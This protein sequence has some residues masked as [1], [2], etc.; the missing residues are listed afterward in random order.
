MLRKAN[1]TIAAAGLAILAA[2][3][4]WY[5]HSQS[6]RLEASSHSP[7]G[8]MGTECVL[9]AVTRCSERARGSVALTTAED[10]LRDVESRMSRRLSASELSLLNAAPAGRLVRLSPETLEVLQISKKLTLQTAGAFNVTCLPVIELWKR[11][12]K[13]GRTPTETELI[14]ARHK[15]G[16]RHIELLKNG[17]RKRIDG[18]AVDLG[19]IAKGYAIDKAVRAMIDA[20]A[21]GGMVNVGGDLRCFGSNEENKPWVVKIRHPFDKTRTCAALSLN[22]DAVATSGDYHR[23]YKISGKRYSHVVDP[24]NGRAL[25]AGHAPSVTVVSLAVGDTPP[26]ATAA[27]AWATA[28]SVLGPDGF[29]ILYDFSGLEALIITGEPG[30]YEI[31]TTKGFKPLLKTGTRIELD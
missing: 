26:S 8:I 17:A 9:T 1:I 22:D 5:L 24:R 18:A 25:P 7:G 11:A 23:Y 4:L 30:K 6:G 31:H 29:K 2:L 13:T 10:A 20:G 16:W 21:V 12:A 14:Q 27:D 15:R 3:G 28:L 19:A